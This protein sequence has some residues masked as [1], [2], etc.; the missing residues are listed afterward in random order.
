MCVW[1]DI[2]YSQ[3]SAEGTAK[4]VKTHCNVVGGLAKAQ[5]PGWAECF[6]KSRRKGER[7]RESRGDSKKMGR[8][9]ER[10]RER[11]EREKEM[12]GDGWRGREGEKLRE[13]RVHERVI[14]ERKAWM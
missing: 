11:G 10:E 9:R 5:T 8:E 2:T 4:P 13:N 3:C 14:A 1:N 6:Q 7:E 12:V